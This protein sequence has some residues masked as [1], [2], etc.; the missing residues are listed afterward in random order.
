M[1]MTAKF[2]KQLGAIIIGMALAW[3]VSAQFWS[4]SPA[5]LPDPVAFVTT[6][7]LGDIKQA[8]AWLDAGLPPDFMGSRIGS[9]LMIGA[10]EGNIE[11]MRLFISRGA[12]INRMNGN[13]ETALVLAAWR[14]QLEAAKWL[15][16]RG[17]R[18]N[19]P[20]RQWSA[21]H[22]AVFAGHREMAEYL[23]G[24]GADIN[25]LSTNG[26]SVLMMAVYE[27]R[28][29]M[30]RLLI[31]K[32]ASRKVKNDWG[33]GALEWA[34]RYNHLGIGRLVSN[35]EEFNVAVSQPKESW[36]QAS[37]SLRMSRELEELLEMRDELVRRGASTEAVDKRIAVE[38]VRVMRADT[39][40]A[41]GP[42][43]AATMEI[44]ASRKA[45]QEQEARII[46][47]ETP[48][49]AAP[50]PAS[51]KPPGGKAAAGR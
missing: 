39:E 43:R 17:A 15:I 6:L 23:I 18:I 2:A 49:M 24:E 4:R 48:A 46:Y 51:E 42:Q 5:A 35:P 50:P 38:R 21:L 8:K 16:A 40:S 22:Y 13:G 26:S 33:D 32:G 9:G 41:S 47:D 14:G 28:E 36:G 30:A 25:A 44:T 37:R 1:S 12:N 19:A 31:E 20:H 45:P 10:W 29:E 7:E 11:L 34:M 27:G 3:P